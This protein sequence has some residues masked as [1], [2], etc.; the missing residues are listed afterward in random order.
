[1]AAIIA[2]EN[3]NGPRYG[4]SC[5]FFWKCIWIYSYQWDGWGEEWMG[6]GSMVGREAINIASCNTKKREEVWRD[7]NIERALELENLFATIGVPICG[8]LSL[9]LFKSF[10][11]NLVQWNIPLL[12]IHTAQKQAGHGHN[13]APTLL[14]DP[15]FAQAAIH[16]E[17]VQRVLCYQDCYLGGRPVVAHSA[18]GKGNKLNRYW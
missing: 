18:W 7:F 14:Y 8:W 1:M 9:Q 6:V 13:D 12:W 17:L 10:M 3:C 2:P 4:G 16:P 11:L 5:Q 15:R